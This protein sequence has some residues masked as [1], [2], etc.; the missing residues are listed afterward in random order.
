MNKRL[1]RDCLKISKDYLPKH[2]ERNTGNYYHYSFIVQRNKIVEYS[3]NN[4]GE[5]PKHFGY[6]NRGTWDDFAPK[7]HAEYNVYMKAKGLLLRDTAWEIVNV[8][9]NTD[10]IMRNSTPCECCYGFIKVMGCEKCYFT[11]NSGFAKM[12]I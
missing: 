2:P 12:V 1:L 3:T 4:S 11:T 9:L 10:G 5:P 7:R 8:R 6:H